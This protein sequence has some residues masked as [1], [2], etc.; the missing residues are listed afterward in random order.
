M[1][2]VNLQTKIFSCQN[3][4]LS[5]FEFLALIGGLLLLLSGGRGSGGFLSS[6]LCLQNSHDDLLLLDQ[7]RPDDSF[8]DGG[9]AKVSTIGSRHTLVSLRHVL[10]RCGTGRLDTLEL[11]AS[12]AAS[13]DFGSLLLVQINELSAGRLGNAAFVAQRRVRHPTPETKSLNHFSF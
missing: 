13:R 9:G 11:D 10:Q 3:I 6:L 1:K 5:T 4:I 8:P 2:L 7:E 12:I